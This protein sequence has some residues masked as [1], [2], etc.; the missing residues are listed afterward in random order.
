MASITLR[1]K[2]QLVAAGMAMATRYKPDGM[3]DVVR[4][5]RATRGLSTAIARALGTSRA[6]VYQWKRVPPHWVH[7]VAKITG[8]R[9]SELRPDIFPPK[10][11]R[12]T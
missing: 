8:L 3:D 2:A 9:A 10:R 11:K 1:F 4:E 12:R 6:A 5:I 7:Q